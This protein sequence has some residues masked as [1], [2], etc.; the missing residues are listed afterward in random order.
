[1]I[2]YLF[3]LYFIILFCSYCAASLNEQQPNINLDYM[4][5]NEFLDEFDNDLDDLDGV[6]DDSDDDLFDMGFSDSD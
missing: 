5:I 1:M 6:D 3:I 2:T 4:Q